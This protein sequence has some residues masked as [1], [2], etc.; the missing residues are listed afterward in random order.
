MKIRSNLN[1]IFSATGDVA[2]L[3]ALFLF[4]AV[5]IITYITDDN[6]FTNR[7]LNYAL[8]ALISGFVF[9]AIASTRQNTSTKQ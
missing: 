3:L 7:L 1:K 5:A 2:V 9:L 8:Y 4:L 6:S